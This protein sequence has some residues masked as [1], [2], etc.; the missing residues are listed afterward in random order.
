MPSPPS[1]AIGH[2]CDPEKE[3]V[4]HQEVTHYCNKKKNIPQHLFILYTC[5]QTQKL[6][7][8]YTHTHTAYI[9][10]YIHTLWFNKIFITKWLLTLMLNNAFPLLWTVKVHRNYYIKKS[11]QMYV[12]QKGDLPNIQHNAS[13][14]MNNSHYRQSLPPA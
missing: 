12:L 1:P 7:Y 9:L 11:S 14:S 10:Y 5:K 8:I 6:I 13:L 4:Q 3:V 2:S